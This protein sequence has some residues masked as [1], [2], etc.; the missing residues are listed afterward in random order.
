MAERIEAHKQRLDEGRAR[1]DYVLDRVGDGW[2]KQV[3]ADGAAWTVKQLAVHLMIS[4]KGQTNTIKGIAA[5]QEVV[6]AD[7]DLQRYNERS[8]QKRA[9]ASIAEI[10]E[11]LTASKAERDAWLATID[12]ATLEIK[13]RHAS[14]LILS[15]GQILDVMA[16]HETEHAND[17]ARV[18]KID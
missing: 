4:D 8:V 5:G 3:Y 14:G 16:N 1:L 12:D 10:R 6:P 15:V 13:G 11:A 9:D 18:L 2:E 7:F 17:I